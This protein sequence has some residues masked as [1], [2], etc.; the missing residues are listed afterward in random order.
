MTHELAIEGAFRA[1]DHADQKIGSWSDRA[2][3]FFVNWA[4]KHGGEFMTEDV[5]MAAEK[6]KGYVPPPDERAWGAIIL[7]AK[8][9]GL[10]EHAGFAPMKSRNCHGNPKSVWRWKG[11]L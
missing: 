10:L 2:Y 1:M 11:Q 9:K 8:R 4:T 6:A 7:R 5:R 3:N